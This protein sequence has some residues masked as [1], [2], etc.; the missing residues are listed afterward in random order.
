MSAWVRYFFPAIEPYDLSPDD[1][2]RIWREA[3]YL[4]IKTKPV[5][6]EGL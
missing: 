4:L 2:A 3:Q 5:K 6:H 1:F